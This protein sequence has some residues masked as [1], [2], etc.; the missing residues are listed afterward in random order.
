MG[1]L[2]EIAGGLEVAEDP[3]LDPVVFAPTEV[4]A[5]LAAVL[6]LGI[7]RTRCLMCSWK[8]HV[9]FSARANDFLHM[10]LATLDTAL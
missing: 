1:H 9:L 6:D 10:F 3:A 7:F 5:R 8:A 4:A 2:A